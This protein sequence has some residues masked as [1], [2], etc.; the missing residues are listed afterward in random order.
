MQNNQ[1]QL[2]ISIVSEVKTTPYEPFEPKTWNSFVVAV[3]YW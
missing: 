3:V 2:R 1:K